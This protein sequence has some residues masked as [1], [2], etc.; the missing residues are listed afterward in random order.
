[1][2]LD[3]KRRG[4]TSDPNQ[5]YDPS[6]GE[7]EDGLLVWLPRKQQSIFGRDWFQ[8]AQHTLKTINSHRRELGLEGIVVFNALM[9]RLDFENYIQVSQRSICDELQM[10]P[11]NVSRAVKRL[12]DLGF[13]M[14][15]PKVG[16]SHTY[17]LHP[18]LVWKGKPK[19][20]HTARMDAMKAGWTVIEGGNKSDS[21]DQLK[22]DL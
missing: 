10:K 20:H 9:A 5:T 8:M 16:K 21:D 22:M 12:I 7:V 11:P 2:A 6:T 15:G 19:A 13:V 14:E 18:E 4:V 1:M 3:K 17:R